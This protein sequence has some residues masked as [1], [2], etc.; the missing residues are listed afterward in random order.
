[1]Q[2]N[3]NQ[4]A[5]E[6][7]LMEFA[8]L[9]LS[10]WKLIALVSVVFAFSAFIFSSFMIKKMYTAKVSFYIN[11]NKTSLSDN[12]N[13]S[14][15]S[16]STM[17][18]PTYSKFF[19]SKKVMGTVADELNKLS[20]REK[21]DA[22]NTEF[23]AEGIASMVSISTE[24]DAQFIYLNVTSTDPN[25]A[26]VVANAIMEYAPDIITDLTDGGSIKP[27]DEAVKPKAPSYPNT[28]KNTLLGFVLGFL[29]SCGVIVLS[30]ILDSRIRDVSTLNSMFEQTPVLGMVP[31]IN[32]ENNR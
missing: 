27:I 13:Y 17:L 12:L 31:S 19:K 7:D 23:T 25:E 16:A 14:D 26:W 29:L 10:R 6:I 9:L 22:V 18:I 3:S 20:E 28:K 1:M 2:D 8:R 11:N 30:G 5:M 15:I 4:E 32:T 21:E 24:D